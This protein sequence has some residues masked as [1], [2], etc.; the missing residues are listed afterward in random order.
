VDGDLYAAGPDVMRVLKSDVTMKLLPT[1][2]HAAI[3]VS[4]DSLAS[5]VIAPAG[6]HGIHHIT[7]N[8]ESVAA[9]KAVWARIQQGVLK[10]GIYAVYSED[11][12]ID[13]EIHNTAQGK[14][15]TAGVTE[16]HAIYIPQMD[17]KLIESRLRSDPEMIKRVS[18]AQ[19]QYDVRFRIDKTYHRVVV[20]WIELTGYSRAEAKAK[21]ER[22]VGQVA[23]AAPK[24]PVPAGGYMIARAKLEALKPGAYR[25]VLEGEGA[26]GEV[27]AIDERTFW[28]DGRSFEEL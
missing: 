14:V 2:Q 10:P 3:V 13:D 8:A 23:V 24:M 15:D 22:P 11:A 18:A 12:E 1:W 21:G 17:P 28:F 9:A 20:K 7:V 19:G 5:V 4:T 16:A 26:A 6:L 25:I 27:A